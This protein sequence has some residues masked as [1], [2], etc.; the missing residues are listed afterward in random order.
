M[1]SFIPDIRTKR[2]KKFQLL[3]NWFSYWRINSHW[4]NETKRRQFRFLKRVFLAWLIQGKKSKENR[5]KD[6]LHAAFV[7]W[8]CHHLQYKFRGVYAAFYKCRSTSSAS[9]IPQWDHDVLLMHLEPRS[10][11][12]RCGRP[13]R[14]CPQLS[15]KYHNLEPSRLSEEVHLASEDVIQ[16]QKD[17][18]SSHGR[19]WFD[20]GA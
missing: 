9:R 11:R 19:D 1:D 4:I 15:Q 13:R 5:R 12:C 16:W 17:Y 10:F 14:V 20:V 6:V 3:K 7:L 2:H 18:E 8:Y